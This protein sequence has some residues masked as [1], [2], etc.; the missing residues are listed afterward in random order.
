MNIQAY[1]KTLR[2]GPKVYCLNVRCAGE[3][4]LH[5]VYEDKELAEAERD[6]YNANNRGGYLGTAS[7]D[8]YP[9]VTREALSLLERPTHTDEGDR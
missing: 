8:I 9:I 7:V 4:S 6:R 1:Q 5:G 3:V 2:E